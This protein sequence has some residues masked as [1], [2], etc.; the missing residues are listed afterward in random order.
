[1]VCKEEKDGGAFMRQSTI[2][3]TW[4]AK[5]EAGHE[6]CHVQ[7]SDQNVFPEANKPTMS[8]PVPCSD[9]VHTYFGYKC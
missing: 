6:A 7:G 3:S 1:M 8:C 2:K 9:F 5:R 4:G